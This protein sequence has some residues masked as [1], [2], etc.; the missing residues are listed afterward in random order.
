MTRV[1]FTLIDH[2]R[3]GQNAGS[4]WGL[5]CNDAEFR[6]SDNVIAS[7]QSQSTSHIQFIIIY[8]L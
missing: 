3:G 5:H 1:S 7:I 2:T 8:F 6:H 4:V